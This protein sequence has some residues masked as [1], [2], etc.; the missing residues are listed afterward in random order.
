MGDYE[1]AFVFLEPTAEK[2]GTWATLDQPGARTALVWVPDAEAAARVADRLAA[3]GVRLIELY[4][5]F[6]LTTAA[7]VVAAVDGRTPVGVASYGFGAVRTDSPRH[8]V[9]IYADTG[10]DPAADRIARQHNGGRTTTIVG[11]PDARTAAQV[12]VQAVKDGADLIEICGGTPLTVA[13]EVA[14]AVDGAALV[15]LVSWPFESIDGAAAY[16]ASFEAQVY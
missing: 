2:D 3:D 15:S 9:T 6:D 1:G 16:K 14:A 5:G 8:S 10:A 11:A 4:R 7:K 13:A 12:A